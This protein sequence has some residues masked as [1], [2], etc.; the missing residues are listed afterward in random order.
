M[1]STLLADVVDLDLDRS[2]SGRRHAVIGDF[3][4][5]YANQMRALSIVEFEAEMAF[6]VGLGAAGFFH[7]LAE[8]EQDDVVAGGGL[9]GGGVLDGA[10]QGLGG[11]EGG[12]EE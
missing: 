12:Q 1:P 3:L 2:R 5:D 11:G 8:A 6:G 4:M 10:G 7:A 9:A